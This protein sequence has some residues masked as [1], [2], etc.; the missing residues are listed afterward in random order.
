MELIRRARPALV[1][2]H[3]WLERRDD[4]WAIFDE[5]SRAPD[6]NHIP[7]I[8]ASADDRVLRQM[9]GR[10]APH[11]VAIEKP[12][13]LGALLAAIQRLLDP[14]VRTHETGVHDGEAGFDAG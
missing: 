8:M 7:V 14:S 12:F 3:G 13:E 4:G 2:L 9:D 5:L 10:K 6:I 11:Y 1:I